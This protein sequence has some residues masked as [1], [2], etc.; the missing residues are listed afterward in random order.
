MFSTG[1]LLRSLMLQRTRRLSYL[2]ALAKSLLL[3]LLVLRLPPCST[4]SSRST[5]PQ[6]TPVSLVPPV[7]NLPEISPIPHN[8]PR[9]HALGARLVFSP[10]HCRACSLIVGP[11]LYGIRFPP[12]SPWVYTIVQQVRLPLHLPNVP[13]Q[14]RRV[15]PSVMAFKTWPVPSRTCA[16]LCSHLVL[17]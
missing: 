9:V 14:L 12:S 13:L 1:F 5:R 4:A 3:L 11:L 8:Y 6:R 10:F 16:K 7:A 17:V 15:P 2:R